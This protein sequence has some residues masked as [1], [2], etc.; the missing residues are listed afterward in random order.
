MTNNCYN[1]QCDDCNGSFGCSNDA[2]NNNNN[3]T[4]LSACGNVSSCPNSCSCSSTNNCGTYTCATTCTGTGI[5]DNG[6]C[7]NNGNTNSNN[8]SDASTTTNCDSSPWNSFTNCSNIPCSSLECTGG[9][10]SYGKY[11]CRSNGCSGWFCPNPPCSQDLTCVPTTLD[12]TEPNFCLSLNSY[13]DN[14]GLGD[15]WY[16]DVT[17]SGGNYQCFRCSSSSTVSV[18]DESYLQDSTAINSG[19]VVLYFILG[20]GGASGIIFALAFCMNKHYNNNNQK[21]PSKTLKE[22]ILGSV[23]GFFDGSSKES[24]MHYFINHHDFLSMTCLADPIHNNFL[25]NI[26]CFVNKF[27]VYIA[28]AFVFCG[29]DVA[30]SVKKNTCEFDGRNGFTTSQTDYETSGT[31]SIELPTLNFKASALVWILNKFITLS[32]GYLKG[33]VFSNLKQA[34]K[35]KKFIV[36][37]F[38]LIIEVVWVVVLASCIGAEKNITSTAQVPNK[39][40]LYFQTIGVVIAFEWIGWSNVILVGKYLVGKML[41]KKYLPIATSPT[42]ATVVII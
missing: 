13:C 38:S 30:N 20:F 6:Q 25:L 12:I 32:I 22:K 15:L 28:V 42:T 29:I 5:I 34:E 26:R 10:A 4:T 40:S 7:S 27:A 18:T 33:K 35:N 9:S 37:V 21:S 31:S 23:K 14:N 41:E 2:G 8:G 36:L 3:A 24:A 19:L 39:Y 1:Y 16:S 17:Q 11:T